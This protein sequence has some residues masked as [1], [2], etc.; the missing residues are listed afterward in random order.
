M[1]IHEALTASA[2]YRFGD[3][4][5]VKHGAS[6]IRKVEL[7]AVARQTRFAHVEIGADHAALWVAGATVIGAYTPN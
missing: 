7:V 5:A 3:P 6:F 4:L 2:R 1:P